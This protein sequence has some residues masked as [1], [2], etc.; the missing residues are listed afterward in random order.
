MNDIL[1]DKTEQPP[2]RD[3]VDWMTEFQLD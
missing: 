2:L 1:I 3:D